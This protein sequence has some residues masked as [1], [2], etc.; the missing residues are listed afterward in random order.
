[1]SDETPTPEVATTPE[2]AP[3]QEAPEA[4][5]AAPNLNLD[6]TVQ[7]DGTE[8]TVGQLIDVA[9]QAAGVHEYNQ[10][11][12]KLMQQNASDQ[13]KETAVRYLM[14]AEGYQPDQIDEYVASLKNEQVQVETPTQETMEQPQMPDPLSNEN[15][16]RLE[17]LEQNQRRMNADFLRQNLNETID[18]VMESNPKIRTLLDKGQE[19]NPESNVDERR[20]SLRSQIERTLMDNVRT[21]KGRG[22]NFNLSWFSDEASKAAD[23]IYNRISTVIGD[24]NKIGRAPET[25]SGVESFFANK[26]PVEAPEFQPG[27]NLG[28]ADSKAREYNVDT[29]GRLAQDLSTGDG[30]KL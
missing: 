26:K 19:M 28:N 27:D 11:A 25:A 30:S 16:Q 23:N 1:M 18:R 17:S 29:L 22:E 21:R 15:K 8:V 12:S 7:V 3:T 20:S 4:A 14:S 5:P 2:A 10:H 24:P 6:A 13:D 9:K